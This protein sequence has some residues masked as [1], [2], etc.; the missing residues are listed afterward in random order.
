M[1]EFILCKYVHNT[2]DHTTW[3]MRCS[4]PL[5]FGYVERTVSG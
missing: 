2:E 5:T 1:S 4:H 3:L